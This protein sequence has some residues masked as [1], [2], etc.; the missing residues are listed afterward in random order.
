MRHGCALVE[1]K[2]ESGGSESTVVAL[3]RAV[4]ASGCAALGCKVVAS[5]C[6]LEVGSKCA[7]VASGVGMRIMSA[8]RYAIAQSI[9]CGVMQY[10][11][12]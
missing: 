6:A 1:S 4:V 3:R 11:I 10:I 9:I 7:A 2:C 12:H 5:G 8:Y